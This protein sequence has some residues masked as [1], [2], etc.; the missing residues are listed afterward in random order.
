M[1]TL[2]NVVSSDGFIADENGLEHFIPDTLWATTLA[3][4]KNYDAIVMGR[5]TYEAIQ[6]YPTELLNPFEQLALRKIVL[7]SNHATAV[8]PV[9]VLAHSVR[10]AEASSNNLLLSSGP[11]T[12]KRFLEAG[13]V[14]FI[15]LHRLPLPI[16]KGME[17]F[18]GDTF[19]NFALISK[20][21]IGQG[22]IEE[23]YRAVK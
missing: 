11:E 18:P 22:V 3:F 17:P 2:F 13:S 21:D 8:K 20:T 15:V 23:R 7:S 19:V 1:I 14:D 9:Y 12:N 10:D 6:K 4:L 16:G 5:K